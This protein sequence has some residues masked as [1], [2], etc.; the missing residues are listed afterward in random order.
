MAEIAK[1]LLGILRC[2]VAHVPLVQ[3][4]EWLYST[5]P[6]TRRKYPVRD[7]I[8][9]MLVEEAQIAD[10]AEFR[11]VMAEANRQRNDEG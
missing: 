11:Q 8:P 7:G 2:P 1:D 10:H 9:I 5:D 3:V 4:G 6:E